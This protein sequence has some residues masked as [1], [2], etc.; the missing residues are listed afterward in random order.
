[1]EIP[2]VSHF[3]EAMPWF[4]DRKGPILGHTAGYREPG[5]GTV[6]FRNLELRLVV[7][8]WPS[9]SLEVRIWVLAVSQPGCWALA[10]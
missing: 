4:R 10:L 8:A 3:S 7:C 1:M 9:H 6:F 5:L 2:P